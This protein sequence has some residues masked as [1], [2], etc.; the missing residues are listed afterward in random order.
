MMR[1]VKTL[2]FMALIAMLACS[3]QANIVVSYSAPTD[4]TAYDD[5][6]IWDWGKDSS[7]PNPNYSFV[8]FNDGDNERQSLVQF[9]G[10]THPA[11]LDESDVISATLHLFT[12]GT[13]YGWADYDFSGDNTVNLSPLLKPWDSTSTWNSNS[14]SSA[15]ETP[16]AYGA[17]DRGPIS[18]SVVIPGDGSLDNS[19]VDFD[20]TGDIQSGNYSWIISIPSGDGAA[21][22]RGA[23][24]VSVPSQVP[25]LVI[26]Y[27]PE[28]ATLGLLGLGMLLIFRCR[29]R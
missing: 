17:T 8:P 10:V 20:V 22:F 16:G 6:Y 4:A 3:A 18:D 29:A 26:E 15:W 21:Q 28:P 12:Y 19:Y 25:V 23:D 1:V 9:G 14:V 7:A 27:I 13:S 11:G 24:P 2:G 5:T